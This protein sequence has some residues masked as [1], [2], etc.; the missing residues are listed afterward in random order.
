MVGRNESVSCSLTVLEETFGN[1]L[2]MSGFG[3]VLC[4]I[5]IVCF[6]AYQTQPITT[7]SLV[8]SISYCVIVLDVLFGV[9]S[10][11]WVDS[12]RW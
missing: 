8:V 7:W 1:R 3:L 11:H 4:G 2:G 9:L 6:L 12:Y 5:G 10:C